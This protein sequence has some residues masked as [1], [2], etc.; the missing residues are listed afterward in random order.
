M[1]DP[2]VTAAEIR[3]A[4]SGLADETMFPDPT[5]ERFVERF[6]QLAESYRGVAFTPRT[7]TDEIL[8]SRGPLLLS[9][10]R[11]T[12]VT[13]ISYDTGT[14]PEVEDVT[15]R[16]GSS[17]YQ[18]GCWPQGRWVT[19]TYLH[20]YLSPPPAVVDACIEFVRAEALQQK[21]SQPRN[22]V[23]V[24]DDMGWSYESTADPAKGRPTKW[25][26]VNDALNSIP[27][28]RLPGIA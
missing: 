4:V 15:I 12:E 17:L 11:V 2:Y 18:A 1:A 19:V 28:E 22:T 9:C 3:A 10:P 27:D 24:R 13:A 25:L 20:G 26:V 14:A 8:A 7:A 16:G 23:G 21:G 5:L 6:E